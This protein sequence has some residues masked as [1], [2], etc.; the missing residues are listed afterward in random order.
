MGARFSKTDYET[1]AAFRYTLRRFMRFAEVR[2]KTVGLT[3]QKYQAML[4]IKGFRGREQ[5]TISEIAECIQSQHHSTVELVD[6]LEAQGLVERHSDTVDRRRVY[7]RLT[8]RGDEVLDQ[9][10]LANR[11]Q[12]RHLAPRMIQTLQNLIGPD[13][14]AGDVEAGTNGR[15]EKTAVRHTTRS[16]RGGE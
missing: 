4:A 2:A 16:S 12:L 8:A 3:P 6:R 7:V 5:A 10:V 9:L 11:E 1:L 15:S 13:G 14:I